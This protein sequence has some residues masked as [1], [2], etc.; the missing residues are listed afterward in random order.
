MS[1][2]NHFRVLRRGGKPSMHRSTQRRRPGL[3]FRLRIECPPSWESLTL[4]ALSKYKF[5][6]WS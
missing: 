6:P 4:D 2:P 3:H 5:Q 1:C